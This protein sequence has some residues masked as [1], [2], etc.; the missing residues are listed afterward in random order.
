VY[1]VP[2]DHYTLLTAPNASRVAERLVNHL[3]S[4]E[5]DAS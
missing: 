4:L 2:G 5:R 3:D 1:E